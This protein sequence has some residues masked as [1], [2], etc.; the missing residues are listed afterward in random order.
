ML[1]RVAARIDKLNHT[2]S[3]AHSFHPSLLINFDQTGVH[4]KALSADQAG[5]DACL[6][7]TFEHTPEDIAL[8]ERLVAGPGER[9][10]IRDGIF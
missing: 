7:D 2:Q 1:K 8:A 3:V 9:R 10:V 6:H 4:R 5:H